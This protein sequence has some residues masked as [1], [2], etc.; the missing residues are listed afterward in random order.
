MEVE[1]L[2]KQLAAK[3]TPTQLEKEKEGML[4]ELKKSIESLIQD[5]N[6]LSLEN[7][8]LVAEKNQLQREKQ[9]LVQERS[10]LL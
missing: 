4:S 1:S 6:K 7:A 8:R 3:S 2:R 5:K 10:S 9:E